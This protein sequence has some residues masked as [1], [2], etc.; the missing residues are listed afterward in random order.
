VANHNN[1]T[2]KAVIA[3]Q[4]HSKHVSVA[5]DTVT[6]EDTVSSMWTLPGNGSLNISS[7]TNQRTTEELLEGVF[8]MRSSPRLYNEQQQ[9]NVM[10]PMG[11]GS[12]NHCA[13]DSQQQISSWSVV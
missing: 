13:G 12:K 3:R 9:Q 8:S 6:T 10:S 7:E 5:P 2:S 11:L 4:W 1:G